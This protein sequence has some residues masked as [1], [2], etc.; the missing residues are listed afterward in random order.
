MMKGYLTVY[1]S[2]SLSFLSGFVLLLTGNAIRN[3]VKVRYECAVD[4]GMNAVLSEFHVMLFERYD[5]IYVDASYLGRTPSVSNVE[6]RLRYY[7]E[8]NTT[9]V[10]AGKDAPW[11]RLEVVKVSIPYFETAAAHMGASMRNQAICYVEDMGIGGNEREVPGQMNEILALDAR[12]PMEE[13]SSIMQQLDGMELPRILNEEGIWEEVSLS[14]PADWVYSL[15]HSDILFL[16]RAD[17]QSVSPAN[18]SLSDYISH[19]Q[20]ENTGSSR[21]D[22]GGE[23]AV[24]LSYL[25]DKMGYWKNPREASLLSC[26]LE[27]IAEGKPSDLK[28]V[29]A[30]ANR[31]F[32]IR[33]ADNVG[34][35]LS[36]G[37]LRAQ[38]RAAAGELKAVQLK[39]EFREPVAESILYACA[40]LESIGDVRAIFEGKNIPVRKANHSMSVIHVLDGQ[41][42][43]TD[44]NEGWSYEQYLAS[45]ILLAGEEKINLRAMDLMEMDIRLEDGNRNFKM[46]WCIERYEA[47]VTAVG[48]TGGSYDLRR[49]YGYF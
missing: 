47:N 35:A 17:L 27:Y 37:D 40:F 15:S 5:L 43:C 36:D 30:V 19:R 9:G 34:C 26:Q 44:S 24:F 10:L 18:L 4:T 11:G 39:E 46:D 45:M 28:N 49:M 1:L 14:N 7:I 42:Y 3:A 31:L 41:F 12:M 8:E 16:A 21:Q 22:A 13:W 32:A 20:I 2:L 33:F 38:A 48:N 23:D 25:F 29:R 6:E